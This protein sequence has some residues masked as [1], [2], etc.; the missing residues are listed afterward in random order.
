MWFAALAG[1]RDIAELLLDRGADPNANVYASGWAL[2][3]AQ[4]HEPGEAASLSPAARNRNLI[5]SPK[6]TIVEEARRMLD[7]FSR[8]S[9]GAGPRT[10]MVSRGLHGCLRHRRAS[11]CITFPGPLTTRVGTG[12]WS[13]PFAEP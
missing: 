1:R 11:P 3:N 4:N 8:Q 5:W 13:N 10:G 2:R 6:R 12:F 9:S 7:Q